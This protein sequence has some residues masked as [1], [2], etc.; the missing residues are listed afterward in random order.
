MARCVGSSVQG[1]ELWS[2][3]GISFGAT[4]GDTGGRKVLAGD[5]PGE[6]APPPPC[7]LGTRLSR[8]ARLH[9]NLPSYLHGYLV[10][11]PDYDSRP[12]VPISKVTL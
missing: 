7:N 1:T 12:F 4:D 8:L 11:H 3:L 6:G 5:K 9:S 2:S 10:F